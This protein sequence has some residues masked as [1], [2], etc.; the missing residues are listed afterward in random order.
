MRTVL[1]NWLNRVTRRISTPEI[2]PGAVFPDSLETA[3][4]YQRACD[5]LANPMIDSFEPDYYRQNT[6]HVYSVSGF[7]N[8]V[9]K[10]LESSYRELWIEG[11]ISNL[12]NPASG[13]SYFSLKDDQAQIRCALFRQ[14]KL[15]SAVQP[16]EGARVLLRAKVSLYAARGDFQLIVEYME[17]AGEGALRRAIEALKRKLDAEG[18]FRTELK[19]AIPEIPEIVGVITSSSGAAIRDILITLHRTAPWLPVIIYPALVQGD[20]AADSIVSAIR[21]SVR[22]N[23]CDVIILARGGGS[24]EDLQAFN[25]ESVARA[26]FECPIPVISGVG[27]ETD[28]TIVDYIADL[29]AATPTAAAQ[30]IGGVTEKLAA[31]LT[32]HRKNLKTR[33]EQRL[34]HAMQTVDSLSARIRHPL[35]RIHHYHTRLSHLGARLLAVAGS[36]RQTSEIRQ[37]TLEQRLWRAAPAGRIQ[38]RAVEVGAMEKNLQKIARNILDSQRQKISSLH[39]QIDQLNPTNTLER[40]Y[41]IL[42]DDTGGRVISSVGCIEVDQPV[43]IKLADGSVKST[44]TDIKRQ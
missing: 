11:E 14:K 30:S 40:G 10:L 41:A 9:R 8:E 26:V 5:H 27:H 33:M 39:R 18:L 17:D 44:V 21:T 23:E 12:S 2:I 7:S 42:T 29:R 16:R 38:A 19:K 43:N 20:Q 28:T 24:I 36:R 1:V 6:R 4:F 35:E 31:S 22:R 13:H 25:Q 34:W 32:Q 3:F 37:K 15:R